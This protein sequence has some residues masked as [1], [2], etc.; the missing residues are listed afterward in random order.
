M[1]SGVIITADWPR[2][3]PICGSLKIAF[4]TER[5]SKQSRWLIYTSR[6]AFQL[7]PFSISRNL[8]S[9]FFFHFTEGFL[10]RVQKIL[11]FIRPEMWLISP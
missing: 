9:V 8:L 1:G 3:A 7:D 2:K 6:Y 11:A 4:E 10:V 5:I